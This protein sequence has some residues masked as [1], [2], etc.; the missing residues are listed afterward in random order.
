MNDRRRRM[1]NRWLAKAR[2]LAAASLLA[3]FAGCGG[4]SDP[5]T[6]QPTQPSQPTQTTPTVP[7]TT[8][9]VAA[10][11]SHSWAQLQGT[12]VQRSTLPDPAANQYVD[13]NYTAI[14]E[15]DSFDTEAALPER[16]LAVLPGF[17]NRTLEAEA[18]LKNGDRIRASFLPLDE[19]PI[20]AQRIQQ[21]DQIEELGLPVL[22]LK[23]AARIQAPEG[24]SPFP[25]RPV[26][27][28]APVE[29]VAPL[30]A[31]SA[32]QAERIAAEIERIE[33]LLAAQ[34]GDWDAWANKLQP[35]HQQVQEKA[36][37]ELPFFGARHSISSWHS[38]TNRFDPATP[39]H[40]N[41]VASF[42]EFEN[43]VRRHNTDFIFCPFPE[44]DLLAIDAAFAEL[45]PADGIWNPYRLRRNLALLRAGVEVL[46]ATTVFRQQPPDAPPLYYYGSTDL[47]PSGG[48]AERLAATVAERLEAYTWPAPPARSFSVNWKPIRPPEQRMPGCPFHL[49]HGQPVVADAAGR[50][51]DG[52]TSP[53]LLIGDS[54]LRNPGGGF[55][56][57]LCSRLGFDCKTFVRTSGAVEM[58]RHIARAHPRLWQGR[59]VA[60]FVCYESL[61]DL[62]PQHWARTG[63]SHAQRQRY[64]ELRATATLRFR[65][66]EAADYELMPIREGYPGVKITPGRVFF[67]YAAVPYHIDLPATDYA[68]GTPLLIHLETLSR[69]TQTLELLL[70]GTP[71]GVLHLTKHENVIDAVLPAPGSATKKLSI[72][73]PKGGGNFFIRNL[74]V[75]SAEGAR[76]GR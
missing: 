36:G 24:N 1:E 61:L 41:L 68:A 72:S 53:V 35:V 18:S 12:V 15:L 9:A 60:V 25:Y 58:P 14:L 64:H 3:L 32:I 45:R 50:P 42:K 28:K 27:Q 67:P 54:F 46:D 33:T 8:N 70:D 55:W 23:S 22:L 29:E 65:F 21:A 43:G 59:E 74:E 16:V 56:H 71:A 5:Q 30:P 75:W 31:R 51:V 2:G 62:V 10:S 49:T 47:H 52:G 26:T 38:L 66:N 76:A 48:G 11:A 39:A 44:R 63:A 17:R 73:V 19:A 13:C 57:L 40:A 20:E 34:G 7:I 4:T 69:Q 6:D 37:A